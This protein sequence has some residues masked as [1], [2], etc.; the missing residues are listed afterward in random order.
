MLKLNLFPVLNFRKIEKPCQQSLQIEFLRLYRVT[1]VL[2]STLIFIVPVATLEG[3][4][5]VSVCFILVISLKWHEMPL[6]F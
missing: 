6:F 1:C 5:K 2:F 4:N 3:R